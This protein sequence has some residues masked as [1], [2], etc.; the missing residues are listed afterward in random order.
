[1]KNREILFRGK[2][3]ETGLWVCGDFC[4]PCNIINDV[5]DYDEVLDKY[6][7]I[8]NDTAVNADTLGQFIG[9]IDKDGLCIFDGD[10]LCVKS[11][12]AE[13]GDLLFVEYWAIY[14]NSDKATFEAKTKLKRKD[15]SITDYVYPETIDG[16][17]EL[18]GEIVG[19]IYDDADLLDK[20]W[21][22]DEE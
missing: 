21:L 4:Q 12:D 6:T 16:L 22:R 15:G 14:Y 20:N 10:I 13:S 2:S 3:I 17:I 19:N 9:L 1:M 11:K 8:I 5:I 18:G 7:R